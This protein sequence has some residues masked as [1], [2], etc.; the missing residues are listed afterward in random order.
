MHKG[1][2]FG[3]DNGAPGGVRTRKDRMGLW[4]G[5]PT[6]KV[7]ASTD[8]ATGALKFQSHPHS[9]VGGSLIPTSCRLQSQIQKRLA[10]NLLIKNYLT[11]PP[12]AC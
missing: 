1:L 3:H 10:I 6:S 9:A 4:P 12:R 7:G 11:L 8:F 2:S 5:P